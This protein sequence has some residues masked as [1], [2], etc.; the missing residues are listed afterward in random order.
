VVGRVREERWGGGSIAW[1]NESREAESGDGWVAM[2]LRS[3]GGTTTPQ[4]DMLGKRERCVGRA[5]AQGETRGR[6]EGRMGGR[7]RVGKRRLGYV[8]GG[9]SFAAVRGGPPVVGVRGEAVRCVR[10]CCAG[11]TGQAAS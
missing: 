4:S 9:G 7:V 2:G 3:L 11:L 8:Y 5:R 10:W 1:P 6:G